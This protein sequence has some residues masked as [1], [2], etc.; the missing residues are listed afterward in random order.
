MSGKAFL[1][2]TMRM[3]PPIIILILNLK[4]HSLSLTLSSLKM[5]HQMPLSTV[6]KKLKSTQNSRLKSEA[7]LWLEIA[8]NTELK[9]RKI[10]YARNG[11]SVIVFEKSRIRVVSGDRTRQNRGT[12]KIEHIMHYVVIH[13]EDDRDI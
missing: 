11:L 6:L 13:H 10:P 12:I 7:T 2:T 4:T 9:T 1:T 8:R 3:N 5:L